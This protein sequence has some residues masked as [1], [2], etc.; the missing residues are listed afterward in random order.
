MIDC[1]ALADA[2]DSRADAA[3][4]LGDAV[5]SGPAMGPAEAIPG[6]LAAMN[7]KDKSSDKRLSGVAGVKALLEKAAVRSQPF[8]HTEVLP[9][10]LTLCSDK[11]K[12]VQAAA[13]D[14]LETYSKVINP[15]S[16]RVLLPH[17][18]KGFGIKEKWTTRVAALNFLAQLTETAPS[19]L[20]VC[21]PDIVPLISEPMTDSKKET[22]QAGHDAFCKVCKIVGNRDITPFV[23]VLAD[24]IAKPENTPD[25]VHKLGATTFVQQVEAPT[26]AIMT[27]LLAKGLAHQQAVAIKRLACKITDNMCKLVEDAQDAFLFIPKLLPG[28]QKVFD[29]VPDPECR[30]VAGKALEVLNHLVKESEALGQKKEADALT[31]MQSKAPKAFEKAAPVAEFCAAMCSQLSFMRCYIPSEWTET[32]SPFLAGVSSDAEI[33]T[34]AN[35]TLEQCKKATA[36]KRPDEVESED[37]VELCNC[38]FKLAYGGLILLNNAQLKLMKGKRYGLCGPNGCGKSTLMK[39]IANGQL[40]GFPSPEELKTVYVEHDIQGVAEDT[41]VVDFAH[42]VCSETKSREDVEKVLTSVG[43]N[44]ER[45][46]MPIA[47]LSGGW[48]MKLAL[49]RAILMDAKIFLLDEPTN[50]LDVT[51]VQWLVDFLNGSSSTSLIVSHDSGFLDNVCTHII[52]YEQ[53]K[54][55]TYRGNLSE[56]VKKVPEAQ[57]YYSFEAAAFTFHFPE[58]G[59]L[60]GVKNKDKAI[61]KMSQVDFTYP[62]TERQ[63]LGGCSLQVSMASRVACVGPNGAGKSTL[64]K[65]LTGEVKATI[66]TVW[67][68]PN[69]RIAY[70]AQHAFHHVEQHVDKTPNEYIQ[71]R[72]AGGEDKENQTKVDRQLS[73]EEEKKMKEKLVIDGQKREIEKL[74][75]RRKHKNTYEYEVKFVGLEDDKNIYMIRDDLEDLGFEKMVARVDEEEAARMGMVSRPLTK[76]NIEQHLADVGLDAEFATHSRIRGLSGGQKVKVVIGAAMWNQPHILVMDEPTNYLDRDSLGALASA[77]KEYGGGVVI[78]S[79]NAEFCKTMCQ[80]EWSV[81]GDGIVHITGNQY[82]QEKLKEQ[83]IQDEVTDALGNTIKVKAPK[84]KLS[85]KELKAKIKERKAKLDRGDEVSSD[86]DGLYAEHGC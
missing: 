59:Y 54:L 19:E 21:L 60:E 15:Y 70:V 63:I 20:S 80:E 3:A 39:A 31:V 84:K 85:R 74:K 6:L 86:P 13:A 32:I 78:I 62:G 45:R 73:A 75:G 23:E 24:T 72:F 48:K 44:D 69:L 79:H 81:P 17:I 33:S 2:T 64:I 14:C 57:S 34:M 8:L 36:V 26:L 50:H 52:H 65:L 67:K 66:G 47:S 40:E 11:S 83:V 55:K 27:P 46:G 77:I 5:A 53:R 12:D 82:K 9:L 22:K 38:Q 16:V 28:V 76:A 51:N 61:M 10:L 49:V 7:D 25:C 37:G 43:F 30:Q 42:M 41:P 29:E 56:F 68:H 58:P 1:S 18:Y 4:A 71:W 35:E